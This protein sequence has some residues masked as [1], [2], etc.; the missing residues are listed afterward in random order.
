MSITALIEKYDTRV[1]R[2]T[3]YPTAP[4]F[5]L[6]VDA[7][8]YGGWLA[9]LPPEQPVSLYLHV[10]FCE[11]LCLYCGCNTGVVRQEGPRAS[12][13]DAMAREIALVRAAIGQ[14]LRVTHVHWGGG[15]PTALPARSLLALMTTLRDAFD[16]AQGAEVAVEIDPRHFPDD[17]L[18]ALVD[19][20]VNRVSLGV[21]DF[22]PRVQ[23]AVRRIQCEALTRSVAERVR[24]RGIGA[25][26][27]DL[28]YGLPY[29]TA[30]SVA[31]TARRA[32]GLAP[33]RL[34]VFGY[35][36]VPWMKKHQSLLPEDAL[37]G[38]AERF[39]QRGETERVLTAAGYVAIGL[40]HF[41]APT[42]SLAQ[43]AGAQALNRNFQG[44]TVDDAPTLIGFGASAI[45]RLPQ[46][47]AQN[48]TKVG[49]Y[50]AAIGRGELPIARG[51]AVTADDI[52]RRDIIERIMC[53]L[54]VD[55]AERAATHGQDAAPLLRD[56]S[57]LAPMEAD[58]LVCRTGA[59]IAITEA[60]RPFVRSVAAAFDTYLA[61]TQ[62]E[63][64][65]RHARAI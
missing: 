39:A 35:A 3:S 41:A 61:R 63:G 60:G 28:M 24:A 4:H 55:L 53:D 52:L 47:Y 56:A 9:A 1:P 57:L 44:Y 22:S 29:Q 33:D 51:I 25:V 27:V 58:G 7:A 2:Y 38:P 46:G 8:A 45:G 15:T 37:P 42:D 26:N 34:A 50:L 13:A 59:R 17:R 19:M 30:E 12:Y 16:I 23:Q 5:S 11:Q 64:A 48:H 14:R 21:Q 49:A 36:H 20:G 62:A 18:D 31:D 10:P 6:A 40:D 54:H 32:I 65:A 43:A